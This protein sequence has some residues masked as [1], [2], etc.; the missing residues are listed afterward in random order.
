VFPADYP[1]P[2]QLDLAAGIL[3]T[4]GLGV[5]V[6]DPS[7]RIVIWNRWMET[8]SRSPAASVIGKTLTEV[9]GDSM[10]G[11]ALGVIEKTLTGNLLFDHTPISSKTPFPLYRA[12]AD[13]DRDERIPQSVKVS[14]LPVQ[15]HASHCLIEIADISET[16]AREQALHEQATQL[17]WQSFSDGLTGIANRR[18]F[19]THIEHEFRR[20]RRTKSPL[21][22]IMLDVDCFKK[23][24]D[25]Y[26]H[27]KGDECLV[28][29]AQS[30]S[31][32][33]GR[34]NDLLARYGGEEFMA[35]LPDTNTFGARNV[36]ATM[37]EEVE[38][39][40]IEHAYSDVASHVTISIGVASQVPDNDT[41]IA[42]LIGAADRALYRAKNQGKNCM[43]V[44][45]EA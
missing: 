20:A 38:K 24:N 16:E 1:P 21:A 17:Q 43:V 5:V 36:A 18:R 7:R 10:S 35:V 37:R 32:L 40:C 28:R 25:N 6:L 42:H 4:V 44:Y 22:L 26:G 39:L 29:I 3:Q 14:L 15:G 45:G 31:R 23:Y 9:F 27:Q 8:Y 30:L 2:Q 34:P 33:L 11:R 41:A 12:A 13:R 19:D